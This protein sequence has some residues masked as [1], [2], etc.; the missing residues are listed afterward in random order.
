MIKTIKKKLGSVKIPVKE[1]IF[2]AGYGIGASIVILGA[3]FK[4]VHWEYANEMLIV[5]MITE[6]IIFAISAFEKPLKTYEWDK[7]I[8]FENGKLD[9]QIDPNLF[10]NIATQAG[11]TAAPSYG[12]VAPSQQAQQTMQASQAPQAVQAPQTVPNAYPGVSN[13]EGLSDDDAQRLSQSIQNLAKTAGQLN[14]IAEFS[15]ETERFANNIR[16]VSENTTRYAQN[17]EMLI[18]STQNLQEI[19]QRI[20]MDTEKIEVNTREYRSRVERI[21]SNLAGMNSIYEIQLKD[22]HAQSVYFHNQSEI[23]KKMAV[24]MNNITGEMSKLLEVSDEF[25]LATEK[26]KTN[27]NELADNIAKLNGIYGNMLNAMN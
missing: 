23:S 10:G 27:A 12:Q 2:N 24:D 26:L 15:L 20:G 5:G 6:A 3:L 4:L 22:I 7:V 11:S 14:D 16:K 25:S 19:Y 18:D 13:V 9:M 17:Q 1:R 21:N 8:D